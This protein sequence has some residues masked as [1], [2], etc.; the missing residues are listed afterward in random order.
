MS[1]WLLMASKTSL[2]WVISVVV[3]PLSLPAEALVF[4]R[5]RSWEIVLVA[6]DELVI[7][8]ADQSAVGTVYV[9]APVPVLDSAKPY[10]AASARP[11]VPVLSEFVV[12][13][14]ANAV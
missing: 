4:A 14:T 13:N 10:L 6:P 11:A 7:P 3:P 1:P 12:V 8:N 9:V 2:V 5:D